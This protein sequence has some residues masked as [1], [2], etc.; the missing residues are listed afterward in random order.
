VDDKFVT[1]FSDP[2]RFTSLDYVLES[3]ADLFVALAWLNLFVDRKLLLEVDAAANRLHDAILRMHDAAQGD[4]VIK[5][6]DR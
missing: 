5:R 2:E 4:H 1:V 6:R 3:A